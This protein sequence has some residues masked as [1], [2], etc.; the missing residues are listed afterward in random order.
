M[1]KSSFFTG[2]PIFS[3]LL[4]FIP[5]SIV[6]QAVLRHRADRYC[7]HFRTFDHLVTML[8]A[9]FQHCSSLR[10]VITGMQATSSRLLHTRLL[11]T[12]RR[13]TL[14]DANQRRTAAVF[15]DIYHGLYKHHYSRLP[16]SRPPKGSCNR[17]LYIV[18]STTISLFSNII[19]GAGSY[20]SNGKKKGGVKAHVLLHAGHE[21]A[22]FVSI[23]KAA[24]HDLVF[25]KKLFVAKGSVVVFDKAYINHTQFL[26][27]DKDN[28]LWVTRQ[29]SD[30]VTALLQEFKIQQESLDAGVQKDEKIKLGRPSNH[31]K[32]PVL[33]VRRVTYKDSV[34][35]RIFQFITN[36]FLSTPAQ[37]AITYKRRWQIELVFKR[38]KQRY[39]LKYF[40]GDNENAVNIQIWTALICDLLVQIIK[41]KLQNQKV[42]WS[43]ANLSSMIRIHLMTYIQL[44][45]F[46]KNPERSL[47]QYTCPPHTM[48]LF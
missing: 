3:Q 44:F 25:L 4:H 43:Y 13:S 23:T 9:S 1:P 38:I 8:Y 16:D 22:S 20:K 30:A 46:L 6:S 47:L 27:W 28:I 24:H 15:E 19:Q 14:A 11:H 5:R 41:D 39:P 7:K 12:P 21:A 2:Q 17:D 36:D 31:K 32:T 35:G 29:K 45:R 40:L 42:R 48:S 33:E 37:I 18:D 26:Q 34:S 10:E